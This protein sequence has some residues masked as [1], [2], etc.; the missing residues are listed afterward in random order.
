MFVGIPTTLV[1]GGA[2]QVQMV[3]LRMR[4]VKSPMLRDP[5]I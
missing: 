3:G 1:I 2:M 5:Y 4:G